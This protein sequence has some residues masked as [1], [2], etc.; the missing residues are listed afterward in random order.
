[1]LVCCCVALR[2][3]DMER[4]RGTP[5]EV[6][7]VV[8]EGRG[9]NIKCSNAPE[10]IDGGIEGPPPFDAA[11]IVVVMALIMEATSSGEDGSGKGRLL[12]K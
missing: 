12:G 8:V 3:A 9:M 1:M 11:D 7:V 4:S 6:D 5:V 10:G 2:T